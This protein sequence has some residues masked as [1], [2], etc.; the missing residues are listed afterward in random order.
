MDSSEG[1]SI[2]KWGKIGASLHRS[3]KTGAI[4]GNPPYLKPYFGMFGYGGPYAS[5]FLGR[6]TLV[7]SKTKESKKVFTLQFKKEA[8]IDNRSIV[9]KNW[10]VI[11]FFICKFSS[12][13]LSCTRQCFINN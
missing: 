13:V 12:F 4:G 6:R 2:D 11:C 7:S 3:Q 8:L 9:G 1:N 10:K 5:M